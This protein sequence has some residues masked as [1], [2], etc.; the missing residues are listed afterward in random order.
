MLA[1]LRAFEIYVPRTFVLRLLRI[2][3]ASALRSEE[4]QVT[5]LFTD[6]RG[7][8]TLAERLSHHDLA[9]FLNQHFAL[10]AACVEAEDGTV[11]K[12][13]G[14]SV[15]AFWGA[16]VAQEDQAE[17]ACRAAL[18]VVAAIHADN[19]ERRARG[20]EPVRMRIGVH[21]GPAIAGNI[22]APGRVNYTLV[23]DTV[24]TAQRLE[25]LGKDFGESDGEVSVLVSAE[26]AAKLP[27]KFTVTPV[28]TCQLRGR[29]ASIEVY[30][31][32]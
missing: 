30:R 5:V 23:G 31:L 2:G 19:A 21:T 17:R 28:G 13:I 29:E 16:P 25:Q 1:G 3:G 12:Y 26:T 15:M 10:V 22:G 9:D 14:D 20:E 18:A 27:P 24:N 32:V 6:I 7:F 8:T 11:D 4:R